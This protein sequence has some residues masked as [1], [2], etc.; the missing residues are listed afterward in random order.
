[1]KETL[2]LIRSLSVSA[3]Q[4]KHGYESGS[5]KVGVIGENQTTRKKNSDGQNRPHPFISLMTKA[6]QW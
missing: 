5:R 4:G 2:K 3:S 1:M 6:S